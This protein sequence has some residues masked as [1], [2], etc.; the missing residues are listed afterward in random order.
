M[1]S[2][3]VQLGMSLVELLIGCGLFAVLFLAAANFIDSVFTAKE[4]LAIVSQRDELFETLSSRRC[5]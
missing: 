3:K 1:Q 2:R 4:N 5:N